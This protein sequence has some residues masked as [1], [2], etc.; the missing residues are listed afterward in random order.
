MTNGTA[1]AFTWLRTR[2]RQIERPIAYAL[3]G[4]AVW[5]WLRKSD[6]GPEEGSNAADFSLTLA[7]HPTERFTL[8]AQRGQPVVI[9]VFASWCSACRSM[10]PTLADLAKAPRKREVR[11]VGVAVD[12][13]LEDAV[14]VR[15]NWGIAFPIVLA[16]AAFSAA[17]RIKVLPTIIVLD[18]EGRVR[19]V[20]TGVT[21]ASRIDGWLEDLGAAR[22][23]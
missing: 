6:S 18:A 3:I 9:D 10:S 7:D 21:R 11:F 17:Y 2:L 4:Y 19:H 20:T 5:Q 8:A 12:T 14:A 22:S 1:T 16:D 13:S 23:L 15:R